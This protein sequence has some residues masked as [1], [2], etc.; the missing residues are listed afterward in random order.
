MH[1][2][3]IFDR[4][5]VTSVHSFCDEGHNFPPTHTERGGGAK[6]TERGKRETQKDRDQETETESYL[7]PLLVTNIFP[8]G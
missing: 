1:L 7:T 2:C 5:E 4:E 8:V 3:F 6:E